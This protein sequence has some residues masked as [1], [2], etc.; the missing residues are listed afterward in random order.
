MNSDL[1][2]LDLKFVLL[3]ALFFFFLIFT[4][5]DLFVFVKVFWL[6]VEFFG[7]ILGEGNLTL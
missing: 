4:F 7:Q 6:L 3:W 2:Y 1:N 5:I